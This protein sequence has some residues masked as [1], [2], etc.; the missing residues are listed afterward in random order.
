MVKYLMALMCLCANLTSL[1]AQSITPPYE[2]DF[3]NF[4]T[5]SDFEAPS[6]TFEGL[7]LSFVMEK[8][9]DHNDKYL[10]LHTATSSGTELGV[11]EMNT[12]SSTLHVDLQ[13]SQN[14]ILSLD[15]RCLSN[16][17]DYCNESDFDQLS[18]TEEDGIYLCTSTENIRIHHF[19]DIEDNWLQLS[20][21]IGFLATANNIN[22]QDITGI[23][24]QYVSVMG[25]IWYEGVM[26]C[27]LEK[28]LSLDNISITQSIG[29]EVATRTVEYFYDDHGNRTRRIYHIIEFSSLKSAQ[30]DPQEIETADKKSKILVY[31]N[32]T[33]GQLGIEIN[34]VEEESNGTITIYDD[35]GRVVSISQYKGNGRTNINLTNHKNGVYIMT[36]ELSGKTTHFKI[37]KE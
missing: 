33:K 17:S 30:L 14:Y 2:I 11:Y 26:V 5:F 22:I 16:T 31:P 37:I 9:S 29:G 4:E 36:V 3:D 27:S 32:P 19:S 24:F 20:L 35:L 21:D 18:A 10:L 6:W 15:F 13:E 8:E 28:T 12:I 23:K 1:F 25:S 34:D 7:C